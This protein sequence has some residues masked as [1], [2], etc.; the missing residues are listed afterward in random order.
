[1]RSI[2]LIILLLITNS[3]YSHE[4]TPA[5]PELVPSYLP[6]IYVARMKLLNKRKE[7]EYYQIT[8]LSDNM[9]PIR[10]GS[11]DE[12][13]KLKYLNSKKIEV[14]IRKEDIK[15]ARFICSTSKILK[16]PG[17][18]ASVISSKICSRIK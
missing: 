10:F 7:I 3:V 4:F 12:I 6:G 13:L 18:E 5:Y 8:V 15:K 1:M 17:Q 16:V 9:E 2:L 14:Y 11:S